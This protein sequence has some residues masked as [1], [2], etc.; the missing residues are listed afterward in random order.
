LRRSVPEVADRVRKQS[1]ES[2][3]RHR[4]ER[5]KKM[6]AKSSDYKKES[7]I[8][9]VYGITLADYDKMLAS[10]NGV[11][12]ICKQPETR[13]NKYTG[14]CRLHIDHDHETGKVRGLLCHSYN[15]ALGAFDDDIRLLEE[16]V[17]YLKERG[18]DI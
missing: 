6:R 18:D 17:V 7:F 16:A 4:E 1:R 8:K 15:F 2:Y 13:K 5:I 14:V 9:S 11:C 3:Y 10:Q 12:A